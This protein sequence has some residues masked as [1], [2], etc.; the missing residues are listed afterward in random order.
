VRSGTGSRGGLRPE[1]RLRFVPSG[2]SFSWFAFLRALPRDGTFKK[3]VGSTLFVA[4][5][6][7]VMVYLY[8]HEMLRLRFGTALHS[9][10]GITLGLLLVIRTNTAYER[11]WEGRKLIGSLVNSSRNL[12]LKLHSFLDPELTPVRA[13]LAALIADF[14]LAL[15]EHLR[16]G[17]DATHLSDLSPSTQQQ[18]AQQP[19]VPLAMLGRIYDA[20]HGLHQRQHISEATLIVLTRDVDVITD[21]LGACERIK[22]SPLPFAYTIHL[23]IFILVFIMTLP[24]GMIESFGWYTVPGLVLVFYAMAGLE[25]IGEEI[26]DPFGTDLNDIPMDS[27]A[28]T[29]RVN[30]LHVLGPG[31][32]TPAAP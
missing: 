10:L 3:L 31:E 29:I 18:L 21:V 8:D 32:A 19:H 27:I 26:E 17:A 7:A 15:K 16:D 30:V 13:T 11:W 6:G 14:P 25:L 28:E 23:K 20:L 12:A 2:Q 5:Y 9:I 24:L 22:K 4:A 1:Q